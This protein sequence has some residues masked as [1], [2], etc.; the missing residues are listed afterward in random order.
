[1]VR[2]FGST[3]SVGSYE[4]LHGTHE[5][6]QDDYYLL[7]WRKQREQKGRSNLSSWR[8]RRAI[9][10]LDLFTQRCRLHRSQIA[11]I[12]W[13]RSNDQSFVCN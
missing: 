9:R 4:N 10:Q 3:G 12:R 2:R 11:Q 6:I 8:I 5:F 7:P 13:T 1:M